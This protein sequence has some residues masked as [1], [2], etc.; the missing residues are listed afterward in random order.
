MGQMPDVKT[1]FAESVL[2]YNKE[3]NGKRGERMDAAVQQYLEEKY[4]KLRQLHKT[5]K[6]EVWL[7]ADK[8]GGMVV[9]KHIAYAG[10]PYAVL[11]QHPHALWPEILYCVEDERE[12]IV[13]EEYISGHTLQEQLERQEYL[14]EKTARDILLQLLDGLRVLHAAGILHR[15]IKP[16]NLIWQGGRMIRLID[17]DAMR[18]MHEES[19]VDTRALGTKGY[20]PP[21]QYGFGQTDVR[22]D[23]Y[24]LGVTMQELLGPAY[25]GWLRKILARCVEVNPRDR[26]PSVEALQSAILHYRRRLWLRRAGIGLLAGIVLLTAWILW[27]RRQ[28]RAPVQE[29]EQKVEQKVEQEVKQG[30]EEIKKLE[31]EL[32]P[33]KKEESVPPA[34]SP[35][36]SENPVNPTPDAAA[37]SSSGAAPTTKPTTAGTGTIHDYDMEMQL[38]YDGSPCESRSSITISSDE[39][40]QWRRS[41]SQYNGDYALYFPAG[42]RLSIYISNTSDRILLHPCAVYGNRDV[43]DQTVAAPVS[44]LAPGESAQIDL[45]ISGWRIASADAQSYS[46]DVYL[47]A[48]NFTGDYWSASFYLRNDG[49]YRVFQ[50]VDPDWRKHAGLE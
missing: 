23:I 41:D 16:S 9:I 50:E 19:V 28:G 26:Y 12:T 3:N 39:W 24:A 27:M 37:N 30:T 49:G 20:A 17:F 32:I 43:A 1:F 33:E 40:R 25:K 44:Q 21:E 18:V 36:N 22:S 5:S 4:E 8:S 2:W 14:T 38:L 15:D 45:P 31:Q 47:K 13:V 48:D 34:M 46:V 10:L 29:I 6:S 42:S 35:E 7:A 11:K